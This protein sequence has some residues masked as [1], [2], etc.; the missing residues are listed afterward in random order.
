M[1]NEESQRKSV[2]NGQSWENC[3]SQNAFAY[4]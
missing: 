3:P 4:Y 1:G 2:M